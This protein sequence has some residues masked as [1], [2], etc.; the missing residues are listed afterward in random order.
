MYRVERKDAEVDDVLNQCA[1]AE[2]R[3]QSKFRGMSYEQGVQA[4][5][6]W[7]IGDESEHPLA[8]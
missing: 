6:R 4:G 7:I 8:D 3:G 2:C 1:E 5:I